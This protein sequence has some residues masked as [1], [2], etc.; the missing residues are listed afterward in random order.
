MPAINLTIFLNT[1][2]TSRL[3]TV[4]GS[5][6][7]EALLFVDE[8]NSGMPGTSS[9]FLACDTPS[10]G[11][12]MTGTGSGVGT[13][14]GAGG[15]PNIFQGVVSGN[16]VTFFGVPFNP[17]GAAPAGRILRITGIR[18]NA[19]GLA[20]S[21]PIVA[22]ITVSGATSLPISNSTPTVAFVA[23]GLNFS[24]RDGSN[25]SPL[26]GNGSVTPGS[27]PTP[28]GAPSTFL[29]FSEN[30]ATVA[31]SRTTAPFAGTETS[32]APA[33]QSVPGAFYSS[34]SGMT[35]SVGSITVSPTDSG[36]RFKAAFNNLPDGVSVW[37]ATVNAATGQSVARLTTG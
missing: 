3:K 10:V 26:T 31:K 9:L 8:P 6:A 36:T 22:A 35:F 37:V 30:F 24:L 18:A 29:R 15:H 23:S 5:P 21:T 20:P 28:S 33:I 17:P 19:S 1:A 11:C 34:E 12:S 27:G 13:Y 4:G 25:T 2:V 14:T 16:S 7:S 32:P